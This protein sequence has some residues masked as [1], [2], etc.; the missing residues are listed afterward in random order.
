MDARHQLCGGRQGRHVAGAHH[1][2]EGEHDVGRGG[3]HEQRRDAG[4]THAVQRHEQPR[5]VAPPQRCTHR[6]AAG[7][8]G[9]AR[10]RDPGSRQR[11]RQAAAFDHAGHVHGQEGDVETADAEAAR[12]TPEACIAQNVGDRLEWR[13]RRCRARAPQRQG[14]W[15]CQQRQ[16]GQRQQR[17]GPAAGVDHPLQRRASEHLAERG[18]GP[19]E[20]HREARLGRPKSPPQFPDQQPVA[21]HRAAGHGAHHHR[22]GHRHGHHRPDRHSGGQRQHG[23]ATGH[24][25]GRPPAVGAVADERLRKAEGELAERDQQADRRQAQPRRAVQR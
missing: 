18:A 14:Q 15:P 7:D 5:R 6:E 1:Q 8:V 4:G 23:R 19:H 9:G 3:Q 11:R 25:A 12:D 13:A 17:F 2:R 10:Q 20:A 22:H 16:R 21:A 24:D